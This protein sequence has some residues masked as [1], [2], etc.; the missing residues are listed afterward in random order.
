MPLPEFPSGINTQLSKPVPFRKRRLKKPAPDPRRTVVM[1][2]A[3]FMAIV[4]LYPAFHQWF[5]LRR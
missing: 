3:A 1:L 2:F 4:V 5:A